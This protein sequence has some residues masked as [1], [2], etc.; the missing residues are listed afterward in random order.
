MKKGEA[1]PSKNV[2]IDETKK[3]QGTPALVSTVTEGTKPEADLET[4][5]ALTAEKEQM[6]AVIEEYDQ[7]MNEIRNPPFTKAKE[8]E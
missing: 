3:T 2:E 5:R 7:K 4:A 6:K 8:A 1:A